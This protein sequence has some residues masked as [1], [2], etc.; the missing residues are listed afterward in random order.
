MDAFVLYDLFRNLEIIVAALRE[1]ARTL[2]SS[3]SGAFTSSTQP[4]TDPK[5]NPFF[6]T[7]KYETMLCLL[8]LAFRTWLCVLDL[9]NN[10]AP[11]GA[12]EAASTPNKNLESTTRIFPEKRPATNS[13]T[14]AALLS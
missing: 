1:A 9:L 10:H 3:S 2:T 13:F 5:F 4:D 12:T 14:L 6:W 11:K 7:P 8:S